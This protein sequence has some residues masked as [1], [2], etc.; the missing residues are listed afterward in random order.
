MNV[1][2]ITSLTGQSPYNI[3]IC[4]T[5]KT[6][7]SLVATGVASVPPILELAIP[8]FDGSSLFGEVLV[9]ATDSTGCEQMM[10]LSCNV[11]PTPTPTIKE[12]PT[13]TTTP[14]KCQCYTFINNSSGDVNY[15]ITLCDDITVTNILNPNT[16]I[17]FCGYNPSI[18][19]PGILTTKNVGCSLSQSCP[20]PDPTP[21]V[22]PT[23]T[24]TLPPIVGFFRSC[25]D[26]EY[27]FKI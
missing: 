1:V 11:T 24:P 25:C 3:T 4:D 27:E 15:R 16:T 26:P 23:V 2:Y 12:T 19:L 13:P 17:Y 22:T 8:D 9:I 20:E 10:V 14:I 18:D 7:C 6:Y 5:T 21:T